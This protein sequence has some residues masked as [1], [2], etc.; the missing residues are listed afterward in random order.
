MLATMTRLLLLTP[1]LEFGDLADYVGLVNSLPPRAFGRFAKAAEE[2]LGAGE[3]DSPRQAPAQ[4]SLSRSSSL[5]HLVF[6]GPP[7]VGAK[8]RKVTARRLLHRQ[9]NSYPRLRTT[10][11]AFPVQPE[12][13]VCK[14]IRRCLHGQPPLLNNATFPSDV[15]HCI[16]T[17]T[18]ANSARSGKAAD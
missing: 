13:V 15:R 2:A 7:S 1:P 18:T 9:S 5:V 3:Y 12:H 8:R 10:V 14:Q 16:H 4:C 11:A 17:H 6:G